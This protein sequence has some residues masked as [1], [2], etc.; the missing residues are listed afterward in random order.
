MVHTELSAGHGAPRWTRP[1]TDVEPNDVATAIV[2]VVGTDRTSRVVPRRLGVVLKTIG[3]LP[4][5]ARHRLAH[6]THLDTAFTNVDPQV[7]ESY[8]RRIV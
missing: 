8:H 1:L 6:A 5:R 2:A 3:L 4:D 7:R